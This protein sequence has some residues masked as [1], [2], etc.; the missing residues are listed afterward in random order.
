MKAKCNIPTSGPTRISGDD[1]DK[2]PGT[3]EDNATVHRFTEETHC[4]PFLS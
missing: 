4:K 3:S 2:Q 1:H